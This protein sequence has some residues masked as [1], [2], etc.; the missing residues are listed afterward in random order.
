MQVTQ[1]AS[2][3]QLLQGTDVMEPHAPGPITTP[4][5]RTV[6]KGRIMICIVHVNC[7]DASL[8]NARS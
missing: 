7:A 3:I 4:H 5:C 8:A 2:D 1:L 6:N